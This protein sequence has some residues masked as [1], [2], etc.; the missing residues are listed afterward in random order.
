MFMVDISVAKGFIYIIFIIVYLGM[1][2]GRLP[3]L[4]LDR[5]G[6]VLLGA[7]TLFVGVEKLGM[8]SLLDIDSSTILL[9]FGFMVISAQFRQSGFYTLVTQFA[10]SLPLSPLQFLAL[11]IILSATLSSLLSNDIVCLAMT[12]ILG[13][14]C[15][16]KKLYPLP[17]LLALACSSNIGSA[18]TLIGNPQ[19]MLIGQQLHLSFSRYFLFSLVPV[20]L[21]LIALWAII[22]YIF[23]NNWHCHVEKMPTMPEIPFDL[24]QTAKGMGVLAGVV[25][26]FLFSPFPRDM[27]AIGAAGILLISRTMTSQKMLALIDWQLILLFIGLFIVNGAF[28]RAGGLTS[29]ES[30]LHVMG[31][32]IGE[33]FW[34]FTITVVLSNLVSNVPATM[35]LLPM[36]QGALAGPILALS[37]TFAGNLIV[38]G[39]IANI[40]VVNGARNLGLF[41]SWKEHAR[42]GIPVTLASLLICWIWIKIGG[43]LW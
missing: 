7:I 5:T 35:L 12:P 13:Q 39:S 22:A 23:R 27:I 41:I 16:K 32:S 25:S 20:T 30:I 21:S 37:S 26:L 36:V 24:W 2:A 42:V 33:D 34:L 11:V 10:A 8:A 40:I 29:I 6:I 18:L 3:R 9:L 31:I 4:A 1:V 15:V 19:N 28:A 43:W 14:G 17:F 38:V